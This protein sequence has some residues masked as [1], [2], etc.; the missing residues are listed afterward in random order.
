MK[1]AFSLIELLIVI[2]IIGVVYTLA[3]GN[4]QKVGNET[5]K[6]TLKSLKEYLQ[7]FPHAEKVKLLC[8]DDCSKCTV[9]ADGEVQ[10]KLD[11]FLDA[12]VKVYDYNFFLGVSKHPQ[13]IYFNKDAVEEKVCFSYSVDKKGVGEQVFIEFGGAVYDFST[14]LTPVGVYKSLQEAM[15]A[16]EKLSQEVFR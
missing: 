13:E 1:K 7:K 14:Y 6:V 15:N 4:F 12:S 3:I 8:L 11:D 9:I 5:Q 10:T 2:V 16:K